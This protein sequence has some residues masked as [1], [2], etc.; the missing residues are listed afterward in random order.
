MRNIMLGMVALL[1]AGVFVD[2][3]SAQ[4][5]R[6]TNCC[7]HPKVVATGSGFGFVAPLPSY[8]AVQTFGVSPIP[9]YGFVPVSGFGTAPTFGAIQPLVP[10]YGTSLSSS[11]YGNPLAV[12]AAQFGIEFVAELVNHIRAN[13]GAGAPSLPNPGEKPLVIPPARN[14]TNPTPSNGNVDLSTI[15]Q[16]LNAILTLQ[17]LNAGT[18]NK[19]L[20]SVTA[21]DK[22]LDQALQLLNEIKPNPEKNK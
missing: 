8:G 12:L 20:E 14:I 6:L 16:K 1:A 18:T 3:V 11:Q 7:G 9:S 19:I 4:T 13:H 17:A 10:T 22:K 21:H 15:D 5:Y 2:A